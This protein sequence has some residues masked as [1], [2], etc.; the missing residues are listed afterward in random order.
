MA[1]HSEHEEDLIASFIAFTTIG[2]A[3]ASTSRNDERAAS[4]A[5]AA[6]ASSSERRAIAT[7]YLEMSNFQL[8]TAVQLFQAHHTP[9]AP[10]GD[11]VVGMRSTDQSTPSAA[12]AEGIRAP[13]ATQTM[14][15]IEDRPPPSRRRRGQQYHLDPRLMRGAYA[16]SSATC[17]RERI[18]IPNI[19]NVIIIYKL[20][21]SFL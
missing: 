12:A 10:H 15:L 17:E 20:V 4:T 9:P 19:E 8:E 1:S 21:L 2:A 6:A 16:A 5:A 11:N 7:H 14:R 3:G 18:I 13:D